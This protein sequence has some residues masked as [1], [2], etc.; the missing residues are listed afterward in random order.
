ML[1]KNSEEVGFSSRSI[2]QGRRGASRV[3]VGASER[4]VSLGVGG[5]LLILGMKRGMRDAIL[6]AAAAGA[7][8]YRGITGY[9]LIYRA[10]GIDTSSTRARSAVSVPHGRGIK[11]EKSIVIN[12]APEDLYGYWRDF[13]NLP[14]FM[15]HL[16]AVQPRGEK[17]SHWVMRSIA[18][19][20][21]SWDAEI[22]N[23]VPN[24]LIAWRTVEDADIDHAGSV[25]F[26]ASQHGTNVKVTLE[27][28]P[29]AGKIGVGVAKLLGQ[30]PEQVLEEDLLRFKQLV[31][32]GEI[33]SVQG[34]PHGGA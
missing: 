32:A 27:Y 16:V 29:P 2:D 1:R 12:K 15:T 13:E 3:N 14:R 33:M 26:E 18:D 31:E 30:E 8:L 10:L 9:S 5:A 22:I 19:A 20:E 34:Q 11:V 28:R 17:R 24:E 23:E 6:P 7:L 4:L 21:L 25:R